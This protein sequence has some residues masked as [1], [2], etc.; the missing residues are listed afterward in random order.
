RFESSREIRLDDHALLLHGPDLT[1]GCVAELLLRRDLRNTVDAGVDV[2]L[3]AF[4]AANEIEI[5]DVVRV[6]WP[7]PLLERAVVRLAATQSNGYV[8]KRTAQHRELRFDLLV[9]VREQRA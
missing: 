9:D 4:L 6:I 3:K 2:V 7:A 1:L 5:A 8:G